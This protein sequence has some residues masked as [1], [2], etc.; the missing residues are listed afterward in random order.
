MGRHKNQTITINIVNL[1]KID[2]LY[3]KG[4]QVCTFSKTRYESSK[5][6][7]HRSGSNIKYTKN[8]VNSTYFP[9]KEVIIFII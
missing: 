7:W 2:S 9:N 5:V 1:V 6:G 4:M 8:K 3:N